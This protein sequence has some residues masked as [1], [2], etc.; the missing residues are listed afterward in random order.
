MF[1]SL[2]QTASDAHVKRAE[3][4]LFEAQIARIEHQAAAEHHGALA[5]MYSE[6]VRRLEIEVHVALPL[7]CTTSHPSLP[8][9]KVQED[10][11]AVYSLGEKRL[12]G[13][14]AAG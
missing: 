8:S 11:A 2:F 4:L 5:R 3:V 13:L 1:F 9:P 10:R 7:N 14:P 6:R 12:T